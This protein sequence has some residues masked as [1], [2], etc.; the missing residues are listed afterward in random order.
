MPSNKLQVMILYL[1]LTFIAW[2]KFERHKKLND[3]KLVM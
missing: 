2:H 1:G 3:K